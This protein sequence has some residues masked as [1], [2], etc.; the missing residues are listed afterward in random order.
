MVLWVFYIFGIVFIFVHK[1]QASDVFV[2]LWRFSVPPHFQMKLILRESVP[3]CFANFL[4]EYP[5]LA[6]GQQ[7]ILYQLLV[8]GQF[9]SLMHLRHF[10]VL[11]QTS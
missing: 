4:V 10:S 5:M 6:C 3:M 9:Q 11:I 2:W 7:P 1:P 8:H